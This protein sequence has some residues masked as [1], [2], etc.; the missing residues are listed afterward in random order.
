MAN[1]CLYFQVHQ[2][3]RLRKYTIFSVENDQ[4]YFDEEKNRQLMQAIAGRCYIPANKLLLELVKKYR[5]RFR[6]TFS[7]TGTAVEQFQKYAPEVLAGF[8]ALAM[9]GCVEFLSETYY[10]SLASL[11]SPEEFLAQVK[12]H[13]EMLSEQFDYTPRTFRNTELIYNND[14][15]RFAEEQS[16]EMLLTEGVERVLQQRSPNQL[17]TPYGCK[18]IK[19]LLR[20][21]KLSDDLAFRF[22]N[23][24][25][26]E[27]P[28][29]PQKYAQWITQNGAAE[30]SVVNIFADYETFGEHI[31]K[32]TGIFEFLS[33]LAKEILQSKEN[34]FLLPQELKNFP[35]A[36]E[37][38]SPEALSW[39]DSQKDVS[40]WLGNDMQYDAA[41]NIFELEKEI[42]K[43]QNKQIL[44]D[45][46]R[47]TSA[48]HLYYISTKYLGDGEV[49]SYFSPYKSP[50]DAFINFMNVLENVRK[51]LKL[52]SKKDK[53]AVVKKKKRG[54]VRMVAKKKAAKKTAKK[55]VAKKKTAKKAKK[56]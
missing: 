22:S 38:S 26:P 21:C 3:F 8:R 28:L 10:H 32:E 54:G 2:P 7:I 31:K 34:N 27:Y 41:K 13:K 6:V 12:Q 23:R 24:L 4:N 56:R 49:H 15:A 53:R 55:K 9:T 43:A 1:V 33:G 44:N 35:S 39:A 50:Y 46:K 17:Y 37:L 42:K 29:T 52:L 19:L 20:N 5:G 51:R 36:G 45:W 18:K 40:A 47:L 11:F 25:W 16:Y 14:I 30:N 48:D